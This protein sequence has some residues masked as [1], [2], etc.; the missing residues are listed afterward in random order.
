MIVIIDSN[1]IF[2][3]FYAPQGVIASLLLN[4]ENIQFIAPDIIIE[5]VYNHLSEITE[6]TG[7]SKRQI[8]SELNEITAG[9]ELYKVQKIPKEHIRKAAETV[10][11]IDIDDTFFVA[12][13]LYQKHKIWTGDL[14]LIDGLKKKGYDICITTAEIRKSLYKK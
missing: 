1:L 9:I 5:E 6:Y 14:Q 10:K 12:L 4:N 2:S 7:K 11:D 8:L 13:H 3:C